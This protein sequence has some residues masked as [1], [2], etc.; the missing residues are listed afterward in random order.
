MTRESGQDDRMCILRQT[1]IDSSTGLL[2]Y[3]RNDVGRG[4]RFAL[5]W[6]VV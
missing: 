3:A 1:S 4:L 6:R 2:R 5:L